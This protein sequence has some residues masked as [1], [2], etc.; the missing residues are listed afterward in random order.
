M[1]ACQL[2]Y[3]HMYSKKIRVNYKDYSKVVDYT[4]DNFERYS[5]DKDMLWLSTEHHWSFFDSGYNRIRVHINNGNVRDGKLN[6]VDI[7]YSNKK[8]VGSSGSG[9][10]INWFKGLFSVVFKNS[11]SVNNFKAFKYGK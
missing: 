5:S 11:R 4:Y 9:G 7:I 8:G 6:S 2:K 3:M 10:L 1:I